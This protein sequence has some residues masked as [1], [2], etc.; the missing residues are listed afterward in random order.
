VRMALV[1]LLVVATLSINFAILLPALA[2]LTLRAGPQAYGIISAWFG[3]G[4]L[5][6]ALLTAALGRA[7]WPLVLASVGGFGAA[8]LT[9]APQ[10]ELALVALALVVT[11]IGFTLYMSTSNALVQLA[12]PGHLQG[13]VLGLYNY[14]F[15]ATALPGALLTGWLSQ[16][17]GTTLAYL[18]GGV[19][20]VA[21]AGVGAAWYSGHRQAAVG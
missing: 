2:A 5:A 4:A 7:T 18:V 16:I 1:V 20:A 6:G 8:L 12:T 10:R 3:I 11:G 13:R 19:A 9:L 21:M 17:G 15:I 14:I